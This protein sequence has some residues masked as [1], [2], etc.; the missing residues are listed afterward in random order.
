MADVDGGLGGGGGELL[1]LVGDH[2]EALAGLAGARGLDGGVERQ[3][4]GRLGNLGD[5]DHDGVD[6]PGG[7]PEPV[8][9]GLGGLGFGGGFVEAVA[10]EVELAGNGAGHA[11]GMLHGSG[12]GAY[13]TCGLLLSPFRANPRPGLAGGMRGSGAIR[14]QEAA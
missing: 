7:S 11:R 4:I 2:A 14:H 6:V 5:E 9:G 8:Q 13:T 3:K 12:N 10:G 1:H